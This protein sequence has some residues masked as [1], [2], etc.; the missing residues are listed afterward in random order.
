MT[1]GSVSGDPEANDPEA[2]DP[3]AN[4]PEANDKGHWRLVQRAQFKGHRVMSLMQA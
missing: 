2:N 3:E 4:D 1:D